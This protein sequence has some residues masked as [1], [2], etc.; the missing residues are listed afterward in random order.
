MNQCIAERA[1]NPDAE[2]TSTL[3]ETVINLLKPMPE[4]EMKVKKTVE[5][6]KHLFPLKEVKKKLNKKAV[7]DVFV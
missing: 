6:I 5:K 7:S 2:V 1:L 4:I 3:S